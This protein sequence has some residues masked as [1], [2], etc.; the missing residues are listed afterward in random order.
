LKT[1][2]QKIADLERRVA[3]LERAQRVPHPAVPYFP[4]VEPV[5]G[6]NQCGRCGITLSPVMGYVCPHANCPCGL[7][8]ASC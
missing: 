3:A 5:F 8:G 6:P 1:T 7:G 4:P 2:D